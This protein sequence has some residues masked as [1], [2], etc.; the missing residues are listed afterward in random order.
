MLFKKIGIKDI[1]DVDRYDATITEYA[2]ELAGKMTDGEVP[3][4]DL[5]PSEVI[6]QIILSYA[7][8][9][10]LNGQ[11]CGTPLK[12]DAS[13]DT[14][15]AY[16]EAINWALMALP[17]DE[18][19]AVTLDMTTFKKFASYI[20]IRAYNRFKSEGALVSVKVDDTSCILNVW[21][22]KTEAVY[23]LNIF[24]IADDVIA[25]MFPQEGDIEFAEEFFGAAENGFSIK[26]M[27]RV[28][29]IDTVLTEALNA[30]EPEAAGGRSVGS[31]AG[32]VLN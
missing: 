20:F 8:D 29:A 14:N 17:K 15:N 22:S 31:T 32:S 23:S 11:S 5:D 12:F 30:H 6:M 3:P 18:D 2:H 24:A 13:D 27:Y 21:D 26:S 1:F 7:H 28:Y 10:Y 4:E 19:G 16:Y 25:M 9:F